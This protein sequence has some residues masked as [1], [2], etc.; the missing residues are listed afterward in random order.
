MRLRFSLVALMAVTVASPRQSWG[1]EIVNGEKAKAFFSQFKNSSPDRLSMSLEG[2]HRGAGSSDKSIDISPPDSSEY[3][4]SGA[5]LEVGVDKD[6]RRY[7]QQA[8][9]GGRDLRDLDFFVVGGRDSQFS[10]TFPEALYA[11]RMSYLVRFSDQI[12]S[13][14]GRTIDVRTDPTQYL[15]NLAWHIGDFHQNDSGGWSDSNPES[16]SWHHYF[17]P[18]S[19]WKRDTI[20]LEYLGNNF[21]RVTF[22]SQ[23]TGTRTDGQYS[24]GQFGA[25]DQVLAT[26]EGDRYTNFR[27]ETRHYLRLRHPP[28]VTVTNQDPNHSTPSPLDDGE[29]VWQ[30][31]GVSFWHEEDEVELVA[32]SKEKPQGTDLVKFFIPA[33]AVST[34]PRYVYY[35][36]ELRNTGNTAASYYLLSNGLG[37]NVPSFRGGFGS[38]LQLFKDTNGNGLLDK[39]EE[40]GETTQPV[41]AHSSVKYIARINTSALYP[42][43]DR[44][45]SGGQS[46]EPVKPREFHV[47]VNTIEPNGQTSLKGATLRF[48]A[49]QTENPETK[50]VD[51]L[52]VERDFDINLPRNR[53]PQAVMRASVD[54]KPL[55]SGATIT[56][57]KV[58]VLESIGTD[59]DASTNSL[60]KLAH[61]FY[62]PDG[63]STPGATLEYRTWREGKN[64]FLLHVSD[65]YSRAFEDFTVNVV[66]D[67]AKRSP[68]AKI[69]YPE[70]IT[71]KGKPGTPSTTIEPSFPADRPVFFTAPTG[72]AFNYDPDGGS[73][74]SK[75][76][77]QR[78]D[79]DFGDGTSV[80][81][82]Q[83]PEHIFSQVGTYTVRLTV[84]DDEG[85]SAVDTQTIIITPANRAPLAKLETVDSN[86]FMQYGLVEVTAAASSDPDGDGEISKYTWRFTGPNGYTNKDSKVLVV[87]SRYLFQAWHAGRYTVTTTV[88]DK[89]GAE[90]TTSTTFDVPPWDGTYRVN[91]ISSLALRGKNWVNFDIDPEIAKGWTTL[92]AG[93]GSSYP[94]NYVGYTPNAVT[95]SLLAQSSHAEIRNE[96]LPRN[97]PG[98]LQGVFSSAVG[99]VYSGYLGSIKDL[100]PGTYA[101][102]AYLYDAE[103]AQPGTKYSVTFG[104]TRLDLTVPEKATYSDFI[105]TGTIVHRESA[106]ANVLRITGDAD[107]NTP[108]SSPLA[109]FTLKLIGD[110]PQVPQG[111]APRNL[112]V[113]SIP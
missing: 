113:L 54:G 70:S 86:R 57:G 108:E 78:F 105:V 106:K 23:H 47:T 45:D 51:N 56:A 58:I 27:S 71:L 99:G 48:V 103:N 40:L 89:W 88:R 10:D 98:D 62:Q 50:T 107:E 6:G 81:N 24:T 72:F 97:V 17:W 16:N 52:H 7:L 35:P 21:Q 3:E 37:Y 12:T 55:A 92:H 77:I 32:F 87:G 14:D 80:K 95:V 83:F 25:M 74:T 41:P 82:D 19:Y 67:N 90:S 59:P 4:I 60:K 34:E 33:S 11:N 53:A 84:T 63:R 69:E 38:V 46:S 111:S 1:Q 75:L 76:G 64:S 44:S 29:P 65:G 100:P 30:I 15:R 20:K 39:G 73:A 8:S 31:Y 13:A 109:G 2:S 110:A 104:E 36:V 94:A 68:T 22:N 43:A 93:L 26:F 42:I 5:N 9:T 101:V 61:R 85:A 66:Q 28:G 49:L 79:W 112:R 18:S 91:A 96:L 102:T